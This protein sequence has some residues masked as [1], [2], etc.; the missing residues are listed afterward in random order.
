[1]RFIAS[2]IL[3]R[4]IFF[5]LQI[6]QVGSRNKSA[7]LNSLLRK[8]VFGDVGE[9][10]FLPCFSFHPVVC[11]VNWEFLIADDMDRLH[12]VVIGTLITLNEIF[13]LNFTHCEIS[14]DFK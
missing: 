4:S 3:S 10:I 14:I 11:L 9:H 1:M 6:E 12:I 5:K 8:L 2:Y 7:H 13:T